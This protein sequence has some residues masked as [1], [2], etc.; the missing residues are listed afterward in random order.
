MISLFININPNKIN[1]TNTNNTYH[2]WIW[3]LISGKILYH[4]KDKINSKL[5]LEIPLLDTILKL[6]TK[7][8]NITSRTQRHFLRTA[9]GQKRNNSMYI[10]PEGS[11]MQ[12]KQTWVY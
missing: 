1:Y 5:V 6:I 11:F 10:N 7:E 9:N 12:T 2:S 8:K 4:T 3:C